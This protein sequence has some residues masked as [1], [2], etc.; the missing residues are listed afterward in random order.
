L[1]PT[2]SPLSLAGSITLTAHSGSLT[3]DTTTFTIVAGRG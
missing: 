2:P 1:R 3:D